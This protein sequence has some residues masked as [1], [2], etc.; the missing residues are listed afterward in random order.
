MGHR[1]EVDGLDDLSVL[2]VE[3]RLRLLAEQPRLDHVGEEVGDAEDLALRIVW[4]AVEAV[5]RDVDEGVEADD[6][7]GAEGGGP[8]AAHRAADDGV[9]FLNGVAE[10]AHAADGRH[11]RVDADAVG[12]EVRGV[13]REDEA[14]AKDAAAKVDEAV[15]Q[16]RVGLRARDDL[17]EVHVADG[18]EEVGAEEVAL[19]GVGAPL[20]HAVD[21]EARRVRRH[22]RRAVPVGLDLPEEIALDGHVL[23]DDLDDPVDLAQ[24]LE[25]VRQVADLD[26][27]CGG[28]VE[29]EGRARGQRLVEAALRPAVARGAV[30][31]FGVR[32][33]RGD[34]VEQDDADAARGEVGGDAAAHDACAEHRDFSDLSGHLA[35]PSV[36]CGLEA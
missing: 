14:L 18:V 15:D 10:L 2:L 13:L 35:A 20:E 33:V 27:G 17:E 4:Q 25:V 7:R 29:E 9:D 19:E 12:D 23:L 16:R 26:E 28:V 21:A 31:A 6:V 1:L 3:A 24:A 36:G 32:Q 11:H 8:R 5:L 34:D 30:A 22:E